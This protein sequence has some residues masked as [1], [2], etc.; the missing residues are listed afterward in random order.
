MIHVLLDSSIYRGDPLRRRLAFATLTGLCE[1]KLV[2][3][4]VPTIV[5]RE[6]TT[7]LVLEAEAILVE[8]VRSLNRLRRFGGPDNERAFVEASWKELQTFKGRYGQYSALSFDA[9]LRKTNAIEHKIRPECLDDVLDQYF[10]GEL[11]FRT[12]KSRED[13]PDAFI[14]QVIRDVSAKELRL[15]VVIED[16]NLRKA[17]ANIPGVEVFGS[18]DLFIESPAVQDLFPENFVRKHEVEIL[19]LFRYTPFVF[20]QPI[21]DGIESELLDTT[22][23]YTIHDNQDEADIVDV[24]AVQNVKI[25]FTNAHYFGDSVFRLPFT[26]RVRAVLD[27][28]LMKSTYYS[29][30]HDETIFIQV[31][32]SDWNESTMWVTQ[33]CWLDISGELAISIDTTELIRKS[34]DGILDKD[35]VLY[36]SEISVDELDTPEIVPE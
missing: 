3:L 17:A 25:D 6:F 2:A 24:E 12:I 35:T 8:A 23:S 15:S 36:E 30:S 22:I 5:K 32:D 14:C 29:L 13:F 34:Q 26:A 33:G 31:Q 7:N 20:D 19:N 10:E 16:T 18:L 4:H 9:W 27:Y 28:F 21:T 11:P 1:K